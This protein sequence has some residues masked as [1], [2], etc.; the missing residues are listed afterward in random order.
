[1]TGTRP[2]FIWQMKQQ[3]VSIEQDFSDQLMQP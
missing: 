1:M 3:I 2:N